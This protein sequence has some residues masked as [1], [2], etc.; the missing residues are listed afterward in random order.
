MVRAT[1]VVACSALVGCASAPERGAHSVDEDVA[2]L[3]TYLTGAFSS[4]EQA[5]TDPAF[6]DI[7][8]VCVPIWE[9]RDD[10]PWLYIEQ[11]AASS[12]RRPYRVRVYHLVD[13]PGGVVRSDVYTLPG[14]A[15][16]FAGAWRTPEVFDSIGPGDLE[17]REG[18]SVFLERE[19]AFFVGGTR[20]E[21]CSSNLGDASYATSEMTLGPDEL[22]TWDRGWTASGEQAWGAETGGYVFERVRMPAG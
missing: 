20:G 6:F 10:G 16:R 14:D 3:A 8:L 11:A 19:G 2:L 1:V 7:R 5:R 12:A 18:C 9:E 4:A 15:Q 22:I 13:E 17:L 21:G